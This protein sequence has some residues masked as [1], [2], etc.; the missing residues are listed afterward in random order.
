[1]MGVVLLLACV[2]NQCEVGATQSAFA[3]V[4]A[5]G[6]E[7]A[8]L[9]YREDCENTDTPPCKTRHIYARSA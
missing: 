8:D 2:A 6:E 3:E 7:L 9:S 5:A 4:T 1:M